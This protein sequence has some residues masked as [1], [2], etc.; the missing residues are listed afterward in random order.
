M[1][2][3]KQ[4]S[5]L[6]I[7]LINSTLL[8]AQKSNTSTIEKNIKISTSETIY[9][10]SNNDAFVTGETLYY[11]LYCLNSENFKPSEI[12]KIA[13]IKLLTS[14]DK[15]VAEQKLALKNGTGYGD[16][17]IPSSLNS[18]NYKL[19]GYTNWTLNKRKDKYFTKNIT[20]VNPF[21]EESKNI[22]S[23]PLETT[24][25]IVNQSKNNKTA[26]STIITSK[27]NY[28]QRELVNY[29]LNS[30]SQIT[31][32]NYSVSVNKIDAFTTQK[33]DNSITFSN[34]NTTSEIINTSFLPEFRG[35]II[36]GTVTTKNNQNTV[37]EISVGLSIPGEDFLFKIVKTNSLGK[38]FFTID[39]EYTN[40]NFTIQVIN[41]NRKEYEISINTNKNTEI[42]SAT[43]TSLSLDKSMI[44]SIKE[45]AIA[46]QIENAYFNN[47]KDSIVKISNSKLFYNPIE[48]D[49]ILDDYNRFPTFKETI[50][51][52]LKE[53]Y[54][55]EN[56]NQYKIG[57][58][59]FDKKTEIEAPTLLLID[60]LLIQDAN[61][62]I[63]LKMDSIYKIST[64][65][66]GY[67]YGP[68]IYNGM[69][70]IISKNHDYDSKLNGSFIV[71]SNQILRNSKK[72]YY[73]PDYSK[74]SNTR[75][76]D[77]RH[78]LLWLPEYDINKTISFYT[79]DVKG[80]F[81]IIIEGFTKDGEPVSISDTFEVN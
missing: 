9:V 69:V 6:L 32:G 22:I 63:D 60:G 64:I 45:R 58:R 14:D 17:F 71:K 57:V 7:I 1:D 40:P 75:I 8:F 4:L 56:E 21:Q 23:K 39:K 38:F 31:D 81:E 62:L 78:Q 68:N 53:V 67:Y 10:H 41:P 79:S 16:I 2:R 26:T 50:T 70:S 52:V 47:K 76:P 5:L 42:N 27:K 51:E 3:L 35:E 36:S 15:V 65:K 59:D 46:T 30:L 49:Y 72:E 20:I 73:S 37:N 34:L 61:E 18:G 43:T 66:G 25:T 11:Q 28:S 48:K 44:Q 33:Q 80:T 54:Y 13:H 55:T 24:T 74:Q 12:S 77:Y 19:I 29:K